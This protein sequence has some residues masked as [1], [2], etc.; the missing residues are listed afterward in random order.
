MF[1]SNSIIASA[2]FV[3]VLRCAAQTDVLTWHNDVARTGQNL[4]ESLLIPARVSSATFGLLA[5]VTVDGKVDAQ[6][7]YVSALRVNGQGMHNV[8]F[9][10]TEHDSV[11]AADADTGKIYWKKSMLLPGETT[12]DT[13]N[14]SQVIPE[15]GIT[16]TPVIDRKAGANGT[17]FLVAMSKDGSGNY[18]QRIHALDLSTGAEESDSPVVV[19]ATYPGTGDN[20]SNGNVVFDAKQ[21]KERPA[22]MLLNGSLYTSWGSHCD[23][24]P[25]TGWMI[26]YSESNLKQSAVL[27]YA[28]NGSE[29]ALWNAGAGPAADTSGNVYVALGNGSFEATLNAQ[30]FPGKSDYGNSMVKMQGSTL[31]LLDYWTMYNSNSESGG[32]VDLGSGGL[33]VLPDQTD[34]TGK[35]RHLAV[36]AGK[37]GNLYV[38]DR[39]KMGHYD[40]TND[41]TI[42]QQLSGALPGGVW[43]SPAY[44][45]KRVYYG[46]VGS[47]M[48]S[49]PISAAQLDGNSI[50]TTSAVFGF[51]G[52]TPSVSANGSANA[53]VWATENTN[54]A[55]LHAYDAGNLS[56]ELY[57][58]NEAASSRDHF[59]TGNKFIAPTIA[60]GKVYV[61]TTNSVAIFGFVRQKAAPVADG[62]YT[63][64]NNNSQLLLA[65]P[66]SSLT[67]G[68]PMY[69]WAA[70]GGLEQ[71]WFLSYNGSGYYTIQNVWSKLFLT[72]VNSSNTQ[73]ILLEQALPTNDDSQLWSLTASSKGYVISN[74]A[75]GLVFDDKFSTKNP[76]PNIILW[77]PD[78]GINQAWTVQ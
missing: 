71:E 57:N 77:R 19:Q 46:S 2:L 5:N 43:S 66:N 51:P 3:C 56:T 17:I 61:G 26:A 62:D 29:G 74:K 45:N 10:A 72:D 52:T 68:A 18:Y 21:Y 27:D 47:S 60:N 7:L 53:I 37:D 14:C 54:P 35:V 6:P 23:Y 22:L 32:D 24:R 33:M 63:L 59:G 16:A 11:Y 50:Q 13:R 20:S 30:G 67:P 40:A 64:L 65:D 4:T 12:S 39:D 38:A 49:F 48:R 75:S 44:F 8:L 9:I 55:V 58:S 31:T 76:G 78:G 34:S 42:Y 28:P 73:G 15:I 25:Y 70:T 41:G 36:A 69:Q 1:C